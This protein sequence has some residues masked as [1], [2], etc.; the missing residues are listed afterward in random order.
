MSLIDDFT[1]DFVMLI[2][3]QVPDSEGGMST[4][5][6]ESETIRAAITL[7]SSQVTRTAESE[8]TA[9]I[10]T[11]TT[12]RSVLVDFHSVLRRV[13]DGSIFRVTSDGMDNKTPSSA[14]LDMRQVSAE[15]WRLTD[16]E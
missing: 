4:V 6:T 1:E 16:D 5:W 10:Y 9:N 13:S 8:G 15:K 14:T 12:T 11:L 2:P 7:D 3:V